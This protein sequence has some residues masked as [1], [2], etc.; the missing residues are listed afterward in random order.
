MYAATGLVRLHRAAAGGGSAGKSGAGP[1]MQVGGQ[2]EGRK[3][4]YFTLF[5]RNSD[6]ENTVFCFFLLFFLSQIQNNRILI[7][8][9]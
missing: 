6:S 1:L 5:R 4:K 9:K 7:T 2:A 3:H 8:K